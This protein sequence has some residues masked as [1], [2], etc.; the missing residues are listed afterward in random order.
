MRSF[1]HEWRMTRAPELRRARRTETSR[2]V[3][4]CYVYTLCCTEQVR[5][6]CFENMQARRVAE[7]YTRLSAVAEV[8]V[9]V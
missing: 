9:G 7:E 3:R 5:S 2:D 6:E 8:E 4:S 1:V